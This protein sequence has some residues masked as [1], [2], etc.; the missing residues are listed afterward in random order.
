MS[1]TTEIDLM[2]K[3][4]DDFLAGYIDPADETLVN[5]SK[6]ALALPLL[7][8]VYRG[9]KDD[10]SLEELLDELERT[11][12]EQGESWSSWAARKGMDVVG[13]AGAAVLAKEAMKWMVA[14]DAAPEPE[15]PNPTQY[16][17]QPIPDPGYGF[18][19]GALTPEEDYA[20]FYLVREM[21]ERNNDDGL[22]ER[23]IEQA[24]SVVRASKRGM[25][26][27]RRRKWK[28]MRKKWKKSTSPWKRWRTVEVT[29]RRAVDLE[30]EI[31]RQNQRERYRATNGGI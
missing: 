22:I 5:V 21:R 26:K 1:W 10:G 24:G 29:N 11:L 2:E 16:T 9:E 27:K 31:L 20:A 8:D 12:A 4:G 30:L 14:E 3:I 15:D 19:G 28:M 13:V 18:G 25:K 6:R 23:A 7:R 17:W